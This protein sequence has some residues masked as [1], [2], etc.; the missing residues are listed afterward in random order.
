MYQLRKTLTG[1][2]DF[3]NSFA[4][5]TFT[6]L[7]F[8]TAM[9]PT[10]AP[11]ILGYAYNSVGAAHTVALNLMDTLASGLS[12]QIPLRVPTTTVNSF[13]YLCGTG[14]PVVPR[15]FGLQNN[16][17]NG[18]DYTLP[19]GAPDNAA[20]MVLVFTTTGKADVATFRVWYDYVKIGGAH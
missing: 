16:G 18:Q 9:D 19:L 17:T 10:M 5:A 4:V 1:A 12:G 2:T 14:G 6:E 15:A 13:T 7:S 3:D 8:V 20:P 11:R